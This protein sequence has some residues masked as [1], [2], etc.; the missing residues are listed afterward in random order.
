VTPSHALS[1]LQGQFGCQSV[2]GSGITAQPG[3]AAGQI[4]FFQ[5]SSIASGSS[6]LTWDSTNKRFGINAGGTTDTA[7]E[8]GGTASIGGNALTVKGLRICKYTLKLL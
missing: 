3:I 6:Q 7:F 5:S 2:T 4:T 8:V 1:Y